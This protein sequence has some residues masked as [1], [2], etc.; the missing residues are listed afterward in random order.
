VRL[1]IW[2]TAGQERF[3]AILKAYFRNAVGAIL[4]FS[5]TDRASFDALGAGLA[6]VHSLCAPNVAVLLVGNKCDL[7]A[8]RVIGDAEA[9]AFGG[10]H[11]L[12]YVETSACDSTNVT[13]TFVRLATAMRESH[14]AA[15][16][17]SRPASVPIAPED[18]AGQAPAGGCC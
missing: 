6:D 9:C 7:A 4:V 12:D 14:C 8:D 17:A 15:G 11:G 13:E 18:P 1:N 10:R 5:L 2:D 16:D 3:R